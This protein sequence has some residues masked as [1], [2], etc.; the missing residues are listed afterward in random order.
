VENPLWP[1]APH[2]G[3]AAQ[4]E[5]ELLEARRANDD[6]FWRLL[7]GMPY[8]SWTEKRLVIKLGL[9]GGE[10]IRIAPARL[11][12]CAPVV[13][14]RRG[15]DTRRRPQVAMVVSCQ[16]VSAVFWFQGPV[17][18]LTTTWKLDALVV[19][20]VGDRRVTVNLEADGPDHDARRDWFRQEDL[21]LPTLRYT[22][23]TVNAPGFISRLF[24]DLRRLIER[25]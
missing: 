4:Q 17:R 11:G 22:A 2:L 16:G 19:A 25:L 18:G 21:G 9:A 20:A 13:D 5:V 3:P 8:D 1:I 24:S 15:H 12:A 10:L 23:A 7:N 6:T 14:G